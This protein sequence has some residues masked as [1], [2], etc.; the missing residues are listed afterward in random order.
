M[1]DFHK[2]TTL[3]DLNAGS[4]KVPLP[5]QIGPYK[6]D[7]LLSKGGMSLLYLGVHPQTGRPVVIKA[8]LPK[9]CKNKEMARRF[10]KEAEIIGMTHHPN[11]VRLFGQ[12]EWEKGLYIAMEF[13]QGISLRQFIQQK[14]LSQKRALEIVL[15]VAY[16]LSHLHSHGVIHRDLKPENILIT[17]SGEI[18]VIDFGIA[19]IKADLEKERITQKKRMMGTPIYMSPEQKEHSAKVSYPSDIYSLAIIAYELILGKLSHGVIHLDLLTKRLRPIIEK[20]LKA[21]P[22]DRYQ[23]IVELITEL[24]QYIGNFSENAEEEC[25]E[26][27]L[28]AIQNIHSILIPKKAPGWPQLEIGVAVHEGM[29]SS[30]LYLDFFH[31]PQNRY[32]IV[33]AEPLQPN[34]ASL[35][36]VCILRGMVRMALHQD[37][38][39]VKILSHLS[40]V[41][42]HDLI[43]QP[44]GLSLLLLTPDKD[45]LSFISCKYTD[46]SHIS[47]GS[48]TVRTLT[49]PNSAL[50]TDLGTPLLETADHWGS[51]DIL[52]LHSLG[53]QAKGDHWIQEHLLL[54]G[55]RQAEKMLQTLVSEQK[56]LPKQTSAVIAIHRIF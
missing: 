27:A 4:A 42:H 10:L 32:G 14:S 19:Q 51:E 16:A 56:L 9:Y 31:L 25:S 54:S 1:D 8:L 33:L 3:P 7:S 28:Q 12:G 6:I 24:S 38:H 34:A 48:Q 18:K 46:L 44:F 17:E 5:K 15:Q 37:H 22:K 13:V 23:D 36:H 11:I 49:T 26:E 21:D 30:C 50:G 43:E 35:L 29:P 39:P 52:V 55:Q 45:Q 2:Q 47:E 41:I 20:A 53:I 40:Q